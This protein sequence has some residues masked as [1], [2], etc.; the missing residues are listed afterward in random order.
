MSH[1]ANPHYV[2]PTRLHEACEAY[3]RW[4]RGTPIW[5]GH[6]HYLAPHR[7]AQILAHGRTTTVAPKNAFDLVETVEA[8]TCEYVKAGGRSHDDLL[9]TIDTAVPR[10][11]DPDRESYAIAEKLFHKLT[12]EAIDKPDWRS[13]FHTKDETDNA[14]P[15]KFAIEGFLQQDGITLIGGLAGHGKTLLMLNLAK[16]LIE[17]GSLFQYLPFEVN[18]TARRVIYLVP[19]SGLGPFVHRLKLFSLDKHVGSKLFYRTLS[20]KEHLALDDARL[21]DAVAGADVFLDTAVRFM[22]GDENSAADQRE[23]ANTLFKLQA[24][25]ARTITGAH[26]A[27]KNYERFDSMT[28]ENTLRG[29]GDIGAMLATCWAVKQTDKATNRLYIRNVKPR[30]FEPCEPFAIEGRPH[31]DQQGQFL[32]VAQPGQAESPKP[33]VEKLNRKAGQQQEARAMLAAGHTV[34]AIAQHLKVTERTVFNWKAAGLLDPETEKV[35]SGN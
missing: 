4:L 18:G 8:I 7:I 25:G 11:T 15:L 3:S 26:H 33:T 29:S 32:M 30:D 16:S 28:L 2:D 5:D 31:I 35:V 24:A 27:P 9:E 20:A 21:M 6:L 23:F 14:P 13:L 12:K 1:S 17:G 34:V 19:E 10:E 22:P